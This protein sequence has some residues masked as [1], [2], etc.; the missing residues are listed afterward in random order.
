MKAVSVGKAI[1]TARAGNKEAFCSIE[2]KKK[3][4]G[5]TPEE[6]VKVLSITITAQP[7]RLVY[8][9]GEYFNPTGL[10]VAANYSDGTTKEIIDYTIE[11]A[12]KELSITDTEITIRYM[13]D[14]NSFTVMIP[15]QV[16]EESSGNVVIDE[17]K[18]KDTYGTIEGTKIT[19]VLP[20][21]S[22][23]DF[24]AEDIT[25]QG[26]DPDIRIQN[27]WF[28][29]ADN[30]RKLLAVT[31][32]DTAGTEYTLNISIA[33]NEE[34][35]KTAQWNVVESAV[36]RLDYKDILTDIFTDKNSDAITQEEI[37]EKLASA[38]SQIP[39]AEWAEITVSVEDIHIS[40]Y[41]PPTDGDADAPEGYEGSFAFAIH[42]TDG[43]HTI[44]TDLDI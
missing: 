30:T 22:E 18:L 21:D 20:V 15:I 33:E 19:V 10:K 1:I 23:V 7:N 39:A 2:V 34:E 5:E 3:D 12:N 6:P 26:S 32:E 43:A 35:Y 11:S 24:S 42:I 9:A 14:E 36:S 37:A 29:N 40:D 17:L 31:P 25:I 13:Q 16:T 27:V 28:D 4:I 44:D 38:V 8:K 41:T